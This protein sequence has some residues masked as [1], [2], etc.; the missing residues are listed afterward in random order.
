MWSAPFSEA[1]PTGEF[2][3]VAIS[4][5]SPARRLPNCSSSSAALPRLPA[6]LRCS[7]RRSIPRS[8]RRRS[9]PASAYPPPETAATQVWATPVPSPARHAPPN[10]MYSASVWKGVWSA[11]RAI[12]QVVPSLESLMTT[13]IAA[14]SSRMRSDSLKSFRARAAVRSAIRLS[15]CFASTPLACRLRAFQ[16]AASPTGSREAARKPRIVA[17]PL[18]SGSRTIPQAVQRRDH[19]RRVEIVGQAPR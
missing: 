10:R 4:V 5:S 8:R 6:A 9:P 12:S 19:L 2:C 14:S 3:S 1:K 7:R 15:I 13:P 16:S 11:H 17:I 18:V